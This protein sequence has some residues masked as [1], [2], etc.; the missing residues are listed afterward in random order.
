MKKILLLIVQMLIVVACLVGCSKGGALLIWSVEKSVS[1]HWMLSYIKFNGY[2]ERKITM[3]SEGEHTF[4]VEIVTDSGDLKLEIEDDNGT[5][6]FRGNKMPTNT[7]SVIAD[8]GGNYIIR[9][10]ANAHK[11]SFDIKWE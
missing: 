1:D 9:V 5:I 4:T 7:F 8:G 10:E 11:G 2:K 3:S 6:L